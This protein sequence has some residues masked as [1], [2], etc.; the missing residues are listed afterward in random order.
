MNFLALFFA[1]LFLNEAINLFLLYN[2]STYQHIKAFII[3]YLDTCVGYSRLWAM[4]WSWSIWEGQQ[5]N[6][7]SMGMSL[8]APVTPQ[9]AKSNLYSTTP[10]FSCPSMTKAET[11]FS[12]ITVICS[13]TI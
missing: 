7:Y 5:G 4:S 8:S 3:I 11:V 9:A 10:Q 1:I 13:V 12:E 6:I 2:I